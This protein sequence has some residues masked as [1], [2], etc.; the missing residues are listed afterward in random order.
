MQRLSLDGTDVIHPREGGKTTLHFATDEQ[1]AV[2]VELLLS[3]GAD[4]DATDDDG[5]TP[6]H[7]LC[8]QNPRERDLD[9]ALRI[10]HALIS[11]HA[12]VNL[13]NL[14]GATP[15]HLALECQ[16]IDLALLLITSGADPLLRNND[17]DTSHDLVRVWSHPLLE[18]ALGDPVTQPPSLEMREVA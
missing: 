16:A 13:Q 5:N 4:P 11:A 14:Q 7:L 9:G 1:H 17:G 3:L 12:K 18:E 2:A 8:S 6:L 15:L 10:Y